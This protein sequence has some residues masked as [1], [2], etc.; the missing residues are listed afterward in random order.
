MQ[1]DTAIYFLFLNEILLRLA[2]IISIVKSISNSSGIIK[3]DSNLQENL[4]NNNLFSGLEKILNF[5]ITNK[6]LLMANLNE[7]EEHINDSANLLLSKIIDIKK[8]FNEVL[9]KLQKYCD[10]FIEFIK[11]DYILLNFC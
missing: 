4:F 6:G 5:S 10:H 11:N 2:G 1:T 3:S 9:P 8:E 7:G